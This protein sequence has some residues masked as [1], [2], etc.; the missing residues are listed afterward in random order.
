MPV[1]KKKTGLKNSAI[2]I[3]VTKVKNVNNKM[4]DIHIHRHVATSFVLENA[5][6]SVINVLEDKM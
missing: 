2:N 4:L 6:Q 5:M 3:D 1:N